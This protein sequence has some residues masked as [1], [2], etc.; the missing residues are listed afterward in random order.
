VPSEKS[1]NRLPTYSLFW[2]A[3]AIPIHPE[4]PLWLTIGTRL[5]MASE[6][7]PQE[8]DPHSLVDGKVARTLRIPKEFEQSL[9]E[10]SQLVTSS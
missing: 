5:L 1:G 3:A 8:F 10:V 2:S 6:D 4:T 7:A 9:K